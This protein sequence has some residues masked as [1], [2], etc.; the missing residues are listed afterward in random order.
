MAFATLAV[1]ITFAA[2]AAFAGEPQRQVTGSPEPLSVLVR[3]GDLDIGRDEGARV[4]Y[5][6]LRM[7]ARRVCEPLGAYD[8]HTQQLQRHCYATTLADAVRRL[9]SE[10]VAALHDGGDRRLVPVALQ[11][12]SQAQ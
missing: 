7:A 11:R 1:V 12:V 4:L 10:R 5:G 6:R 3:Y 8:L 2:G 9:N